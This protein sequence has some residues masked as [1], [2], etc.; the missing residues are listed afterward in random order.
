MYKTIKHIIIFIIDLMISSVQDI[1][2]PGVYVFPYS[3]GR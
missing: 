1:K 2:C 3:T